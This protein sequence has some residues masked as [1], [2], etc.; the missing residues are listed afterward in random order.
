MSY[1]VQK[2]LKIHN[3]LLRNL[4]KCLNINVALQACQNYRDPFNN[5]CNWYSYCPYTQTSADSCE[6]FQDCNPDYAAEGCYLGQSACEP[7]K[8]KICSQVGVCRGFPNYEG[9][10]ESET[11][12]AEA[13]SDNADCGWYTFIGDATDKNC[14]F[15]GEDCPPGEC[16]Q[17]ECTFGQSGCFV[18]M[19]RVKD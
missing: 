9:K 10:A 13:C 17:V 7:D 16:N 2:R 18:K 11:E 4:E 1:F 6:L 14:L 8:L 12:C 5:D 19:V 15:F 3:Q